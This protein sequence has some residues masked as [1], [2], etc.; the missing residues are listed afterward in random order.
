LFVDDDDAN[1]RLLGF[2]FRKE[3]FR[4]LEA[5]NGV[6]ALRLADEKPDLVVLDVNL[7][8]VNGFE[9]CRRLKTHPATAGASV[10]HMSAVYINSDDRTQGLE[11][12]ADGYLVKPI[13]PREL[14]ATVRSLLRVREAEEAAKAA[15]QQWRATFDAISDV[16]ALID[17]AG[18]VC[19]CNRA[20]CDLTGRPFTE[21][22]GRPL[23][24][25][26]QQAFHLPEPPDLELP[27]VAGSRQT[28]EVRM[29]ARWFRLT[30]DPIRDG[31]GAAGAVLIFTDVTERKALEEQL[32][33]AQKLEAIGKL[34]GG[35]AHDFNNLLTAVLGNVSLLLQALSPGGP[36]YELAGAVEKAAWRAAELTRQ[37]LGFSRQTLLWLRPVNLND[38]ATEVVSI[39][40]RTI[41]PRVQVAVER[42]P[43][44]WPVQADSGQ[45]SQVL[46]N[47]C[48]NACDAM[49]EGG[50]LRLETCNQVFD[51]DR[52]RASLE[53]RPGAFVRLRVAD[54]GVGIPSDV[55]SRIFDPFFTTKPQGKGTGLGLAMVYGIVRQHD[56]W[57][58]CRSAPGEGACF[59][60]FLPRLTAA[61][62]APPPQP[63][64]A[65][66]P[67]RGERILLAD[68][69][70]M[71]R[72]LGST[73]LRQHGFRVLLAVDGQEAVEVFERE[74]GRIDLVL[75]DLTMPRLS[76]REALIRIRR[77]DASVPV[78]VSSGYSAERLTEAEQAQVHGFLGKP[79]RERDL[80]QA[81]Q[82]ALRAS[83]PAA[84]AG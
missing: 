73:L 61:V 19:R 63:I 45:M 60:V 83:H 77:M 65:V 69:N 4:V 13:E 10:L 25:A 80:I 29:G 21:V 42:A 70:D 72:A 39:L 37:L 32:R 38:S 50:R 18:Q 22:V 34:A 66:N 79:F 64:T 1:R 3:G 40:E 20:L 5:A 41:D 75:L 36:E 26:L 52:A 74:R 8:D 35:V 44:L 51:G 30:A 15:A 55:L 84:P 81:V 23:A 47:L 28:R 62:E 76:G 46:M 48:L 24:G 9:V 43:D 6:E 33:Q 27:S 59:D 11:G 68:D 71:V 17:G 16:V 14:L 54:D 7:P 56:G 57:V 78:V 67:G 12:G 31:R 2:I 82:A 58:E 53:A 49:P